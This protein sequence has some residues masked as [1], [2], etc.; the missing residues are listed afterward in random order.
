VDGPLHSERH[1]RGRTLAPDGLLTLLW[2][3]IAEAGQAGLFIHRFRIHFD[4]RDA[5]DEVED[6]LLLNLRTSYARGI[7]NGLLTNSTTLPGAF[8][9]TPFDGPADDVERIDL[10]LDLVELLHNDVVDAPGGNPTRSSKDKALAQEAFRGFVDPAL[11]MHDPALELLPIGQ[12]V[13]QDSE[14]RELYVQPLPADSE[15]QVTDPVT[16]AKNLFLKRGATVDE[17]RAAVLALAGALEHLRPEVKDALISKDET[18][19]F[20]V[21]NNFAIRHNN[22]MQKGDY[23]SELWLDW[24]F[25]VYLATVHAVVGVRSRPANKTPKPI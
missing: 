20:E 14:R 25:H 12:I 17:K 5:V 7:A 11:A 15:R 19:L 22:R 8:E 9:S 18:A 6:F 23:D 10:M 16:S 13:D 21:A 2:K 1:G 4:I 24:M 3:R